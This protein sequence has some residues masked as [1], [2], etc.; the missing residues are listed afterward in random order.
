MSAAEEPR[1]GVAIVVRDLMVYSWGWILPVV[2]CEKMF[3]LCL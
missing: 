1:W 2:L 3:L